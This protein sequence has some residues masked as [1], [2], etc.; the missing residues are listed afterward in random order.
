MSSRGRLLGHRR[1][2]MS[3]CEYTGG[4]LDAATYSLQQRSK[5]S[6]YL[7]LLP[8][9]LLEQFDGTVQ[10]GVVLAEAEA[11]EVARCGRR[12]VIEGAHRDRRHAGL[13]RDVPTEVFVGSVEAEWAKV[14]LHEVG[15]VRRQDV[16]ADGAQSDS[17]AIALALHV[18]GQRREVVVA[19]P[20]AGCRSPLQ[21]GRGREGHELMRLGDR[22]HQVRG[23]GDISHLPAGEAEALA[24]RADAHGASA[25]ARERHD[26]QMPVV[27]EDDVLID[28]VAYGVGVVPTAQVRNELELFP[29]E[30]LGA[31]IHRRVEQDELGAIAERRRQIPAWQAPARWFEPDQSGN[32]AGA[33]HDGEVRIIK[34]LDQDNLIAWLDQSEQAVSQGLGGT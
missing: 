15:A 6:K 24:G 9:M 32:A 7:N 1:L 16:E 21:V 27:V 17:E 33:P 29:V 11:G 19:Q 3:W 34:R 14:G 25:H 10:R 8:E 26:G 23:G 28:L 12:F 31:R 5:V 2:P 22:L 20:Q 30:D 4:R 18:G 13:D